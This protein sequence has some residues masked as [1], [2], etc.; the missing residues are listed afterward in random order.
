MRGILEVEVFGRKGELVVCRKQ[1]MR[2]FTRGFIDGLYVACGNVGYSMIDVDMGHR[3]VNNSYESGATKSNLRIGSPPGR[4]MVIQATGKRGDLS[5]ESSP[6]IKYFMWGEDLGIQVG[7]GTAAVTPADRRLVQRI[8]HGERAPDGAPL[9]F[10]SYMVNDDADFEIYGDKWAAQTFSPLVSHRITSILVK[11]WK[12]GAPGDLSLRLCP[13]TVSD[14]PQETDIIASGAIAEA[15]LPVSPGD[16]AEWTLDAP[17]DV[18]VGHLYS[19]VLY[20]EGGTY[21]NSVHWRRDQSGA[22]Y[23]R[24]RQY[25]STN[26][27][28]YWSVSSGADFMFQERGQSSGELEYG[29][30]ELVRLAFSDPNGSFMVRRYFTNS[31]GQ[32][33][34]INEMGI[35][36]MMTQQGQRGWPFLAARDLVAPGVDVAHG[37]LLRATYTVQITV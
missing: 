16:W 12:E 21:S 17:V 3:S 6:K 9:T 20:L 10:E 37:E 23:P 5:G 28:G 31:C 34:T 1:L 18:Y 13:V 33:L 36:T 35:Q 4:S 14:Q 22:A 26:A 30:C 7:A 19:L 8:A 2:S 15:S 11:V 24:G 25:T 27:G 29:G 32:A